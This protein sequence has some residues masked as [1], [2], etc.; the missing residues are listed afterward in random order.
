[1]ITQWCTHVMHTQALCVPFCITID[2][3]A[4]SGSKG[5]PSHGDDD[6]DD[7]G[8]SRHQVYIESLVIVIS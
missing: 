2:A 7:E 4:R 1:M 5:D 8:T 3:K 6:S